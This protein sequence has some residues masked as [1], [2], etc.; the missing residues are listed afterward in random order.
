MPGKGELALLEPFRNQLPRRLFTEAFELP[1]S[2]GRGRNRASLERARAL[3][4]Q[5]GWQIKDG[6]LANSTGEPFEVNSCRQMW[7]IS[8]LFYLTLA[9]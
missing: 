9:A 5:A 8:V 3:L 2:T 6:V 1:R 7:P 4:A